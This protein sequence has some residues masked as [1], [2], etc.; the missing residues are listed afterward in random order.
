MSGGV[1]AV[2]TTAIGAKIAAGLAS[3]AI[4]VATASVTLFSYDAIGGLTH[5]LR[6]SE[7]AS[8][9]MRAQSPNAPTTS[10]AETDSSGGG[11]Y[12]GMSGLSS[13]SEPE[14][15]VIRD[16]TV[17]GKLIDEYESPSYSIT[18]VI[19]SDGTVDGT[20]GGTYTRMPPG[21]PSTD[22]VWEGGTFSGMINETGWID[23]EGTVR[24]TMSRDGQWLDH[25]WDPMPYT[26]V[27]R[28]GGQVSPAYDFAGEVF[29]SEWDDANGESTGAIGDTYAVSATE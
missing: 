7:L 12:D 17:T 1:G 6:A 16:A 26:G 28:I 8:Q 2:G 29:A 4:V 18:I 20:V 23:A 11:M 13:D 5:G 10:T 25:D 24:E 9:M 3:G 19:H 27:V 22:C 21:Y 15:F 14:G